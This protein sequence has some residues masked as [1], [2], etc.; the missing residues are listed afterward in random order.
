MNDVKTQYA[1]ARAY[2]IIGEILKRIPNSMLDKYPSADW[3]QVK[4]FRDFLAHNY[5]IVLP[6]R[7][8]DAVE[9]IPNLCAAVESM[10]RDLEKESNKSDD[11]TAE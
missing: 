9:D 3:G 11:P 10:L 2:E 7:L 1:V 6:I 5:R 4:R 8:W